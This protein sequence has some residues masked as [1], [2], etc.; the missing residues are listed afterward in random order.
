M[1]INGGSLVYVLLWHSP[2]TFTAVKKAGLAFN[3]NPLEW[4]E[5]WRL[6]ASPHKGRYIFIARTPSAKI[7]EEVDILFDLKE[8]C[9]HC[10]F[11]ND[12]KPYLNSE[13]VQE[14]CEADTFACHKTTV[15]NDNSDEGEMVVT[16][17]SRMCAGF[18]ILREKI[19]Q[20]TQT[21]RIAERLGIYDRRKLNMKAP[22]FDCIEDMMEEQNTF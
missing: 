16:D 12:I 17:K 18:L 3:Q 6:S 20:P 15:S 1:S 9:A 10:P 5:E 21:M 8:P 14:I 19:E 11:R 13:R 22:V 7:F 4:V 2:I